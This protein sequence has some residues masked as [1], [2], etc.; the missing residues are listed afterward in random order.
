MDERQGED[1]RLW[2]SPLRKKLAKRG[3]QQVALTSGITP[4]ELRQSPSTRSAERKKKKY[5]TRAV[6]EGFSVESLKAPVPSDC[7][8]CVETGKCLYNHDLNKCPMQSRIFRCNDCGQKVMVR[9]IL[10]KVWKYCPI[11]LPKHRDE[12]V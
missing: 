8:D 9:M 3:Q 7:R 4:K 5:I 10:G 12:K 6:K 1:G 2:N 11:C